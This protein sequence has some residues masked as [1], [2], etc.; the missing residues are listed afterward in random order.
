MT[1]AGEAMKTRWIVPMKD[2]FGRPLTLVVQAH[3][4]HVYTAVGDL[5]AKH[6]PREVS[7]IRQVLFDAQAAAFAQRGGHFD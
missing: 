1:M 6:T 3:D 2:P 5:Q 7:E 4:G